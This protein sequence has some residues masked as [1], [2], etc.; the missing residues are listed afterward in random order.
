MEVE[1]EIMYLKNTL[2][3]LCGAALFCATA[4]AQAAAGP[5]T[6][7]KDF[8]KMAA[9]ADMVEAHFG[10][11][12]QDQASR[13]DIKDYGQMLVTDHTANYN[14]LNALA[15]KAGVDIPKGIDAKDNKK[16]DAFTKL[17]GAA[18][19]HRFVAEMIQAH[20]T[21]IVAFK[22][23]AE[24]GEDTNVKAFAN[25]TIPKLQDHLE[26]AK[27]LAKPAMKGAK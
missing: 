19:D 22:K 2:A 26:K 7:D 6:S 24:H 23:E 17:K 5:S 25:S 27:A 14:D 8:M 18:F 3:G 9:E 10:Q 1:E 13:Q 11:M 16:I 4:F 12:A 15:T 21:A 20:E